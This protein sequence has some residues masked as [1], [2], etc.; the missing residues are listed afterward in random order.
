M[1]AKF[2]ILEDIILEACKIVDA[3]VDP[4][5]KKSSIVRYWGP[6][7]TGETKL[8]LLSRKVAM[9]LR[10]VFDELEAYQ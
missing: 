9:P 10:A 6:A 4:D 8:V 5:D 2:V 3:I 1:T 7:Q